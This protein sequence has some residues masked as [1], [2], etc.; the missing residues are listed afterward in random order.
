MRHLASFPTRRSS[1]LMEGSIDW[2]TLI[3]DETLVS[4]PPQLLSEL[5]LML[6]FL[7]MDRR[8][9]FTR[10]GQNVLQQLLNLLTRNPPLRR[11][12]K[13]TRLNSSH[14]AISYAV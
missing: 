5:R 13:S 11:D 14:V 2:D 6:R 12:R 1:D 4:E 10:M 7:S 3:R 8:E 9:R